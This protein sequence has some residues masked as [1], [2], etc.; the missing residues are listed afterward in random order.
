MLTDEQ[1]ESMKAQ[2]IKQVEASFPED[3]KD[4]AVSQIEAMD[5][6]Q[7]EDFLIKNNL[8]RKD[9][10]T[11]VSG[12][13]CV[14]CSI[15][16]GDIKS[17]KIAENSKAIAVLEINPLSKGHAMII[18]KEHTTNEKAMPKEV[19]KF[20]KKISS[21]IKSRLKPKEIKIA[22][23]NVMGHQIFNIVPVYEGRENLAERK[24]AS[25][26]ELVELQEI[27]AKKAPVKKPREK[28]IT[29]KE[30]VKKFEENLWLPKRIP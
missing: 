28:K 6:E 8:I 23:S 20:S 15:V 14:F 3:K 5:A 24:P 22:S 10:I 17:Y 19:A 12:Q 18:P 16:F 27:L 30:I 7:L 4:F 1:V 13:Q 29:V 11:S 2:L 25:P 26:E 21:L 9:G